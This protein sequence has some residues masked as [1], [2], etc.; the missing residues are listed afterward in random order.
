MAAQ[1]DPAHVLS[2]YANLL[3]KDEGAFVRDIE[4]LPYP[5]DVIKQVLI[6]CIGVANDQN[7]A[8]LAGAYVRLAIFQ[9][10]SSQ[11]KDALAKSQWLTGLNDVSQLSNDELKD[12]AK[13]AETAQSVVA[14]LSKRVTTES[15]ALANELKAANS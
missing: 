5:K 6:Y 11:E 2:S 3:M 13:K 10:L 8:F 12:A 15:A 1:I 4:E 7:R 14:T 9:P